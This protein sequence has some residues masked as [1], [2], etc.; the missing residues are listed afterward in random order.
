MRRFYLPCQSSLPRDHISPPE[1]IQLSKHFFIFH[2]TK[3][4]S[5]INA[6][7]FGPIPM[8]GYKPSV[9]YHDHKDACSVVFCESPSGRCPTSP[10]KPIGAP[11]YYVPSARIAVAG[12]Q[13][14]SR[15]KR[16]W[17]W[18]RQTRAAPRAHRSRTGITRIAGP[19]RDRSC[20]RSPSVC[21]LSPSGI[22]CP[23]C[24]RKPQL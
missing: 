9:W 11:T 15:N 19:C 23:R 5:L 3:P 7:I 8:S 2:Q 21:A 12:R 6:P 17:I 4:A 16:R 14:R 13:A 22:P 24:S 18:S 10:P 20:S 1:C